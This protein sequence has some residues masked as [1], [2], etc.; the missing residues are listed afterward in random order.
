MQPIAAAF[1][2]RCSP[3]CI[4]S[5]SHT[6]HYLLWQRKILA[7]V[8]A[9]QSYSRQTRG[10]RGQRKGRRALACVCRFE[11]KDVVGI[12]RTVGLFPREA[13]L[14]VKIK[15]PSVREGL[16]LYV[17]LLFIFCVYR[18]SFQSLRHFFRMG[19]PGDPSPDGSLQLSYPG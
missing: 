17:F 10:R 9:R 13:S 2:A 1:Q 11:R 5:F 14:L 16:F 8:P 15:N 12:D 6:P 4:C 3:L 19:C 18:S 7:P